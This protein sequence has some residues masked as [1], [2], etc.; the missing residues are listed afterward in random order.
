M[1]A[2]RI[3]F[4]RHNDIR[5]GSEKRTLERAR[6][7]GAQRLRL[8]HPF[9]AIRRTRDQPSLGSGIV[10]HDKMLCARTVADQW[11]VE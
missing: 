5:F 10:I 2:S 11:V 7:C 9:A 1:T 8:L 6:V 3:Y 4:A